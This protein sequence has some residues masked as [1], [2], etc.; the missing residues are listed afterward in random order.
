MAIVEIC[1]E[2]L[3]SALAALEGGAD[4][5][6][7]CENRAVGGVTPS[8]G[9]ISRLCPERGATPIH[10]L[11]RPRGGDFVYSSFEV[12]AMRTDIDAARGAG[13]SGVVLGSLTPEGRVDVSTTRGLIEAARPMSVTFHKAFDATPDP[14]GALEDLITLGV[15]R[16][17]TSGHAATAREGLPVLADLVR[18]S[19]GRIAILAG[20][21]IREGDIAGL[22]E[23]GLAEVHLGSAACRDGSTDAGLVR[24]VVALARSG[25]AVI[26]HLTT[27]DEW[28]R[29]RAEGLYRAASLDSEG[30]IHASTTAQVEGSASRFFRGRSGI[31]VLG[32]DV[33]RVRVPIRWETSSHSERPFPHLHGPLNLDAVR[34]CVALDPDQAGNFRWP[35]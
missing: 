21:S 9:A 7:L 4:R 15:D 16:V 27:R 25:S 10:V 30:F 11:I 3:S 14:F 28:D 34:S 26:Y 12:E 32:I 24:R 1:S 18:R 31:V 2:G 19:S 6:E 20:G 13:A 17:L 8:V 29:A 35:K 22:V 5:I 33:A 23:A